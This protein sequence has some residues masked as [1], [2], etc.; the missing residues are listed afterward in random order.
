MNLNR[1]VGQML[2]A[3]TAKHA[4]MVHFFQSDIWIDIDPD[5]YH[6]Q[7]HSMF[8]PSILPHVSQMDTM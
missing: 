8:L 5:Q 7:Q 3:L 6:F 4:M 2:W 1:S